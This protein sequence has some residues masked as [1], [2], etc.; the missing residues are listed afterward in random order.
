MQFSTVATSF[1]FFDLKTG[2]KI[3][4]WLGI[5]F[6]VLA[7][8]FF[9]SCSSLFGMVFASKFLPLS[10]FLIEWRIIQFRNMHRTLENAISN[11][12]IVDFSLSF[13]GVSVLV[14]AYLING[15]IKVSANQLN[16]SLLG[17][18]IVI[19]FFQIS[20]CTEKTGPNSAGSRIAYHWF[21]HSSVFY[22]GSASRFVDVLSPLVC[23]P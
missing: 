18:V 23:R 4:G 10:K 12:W 3:I 5:F 13:A 21:H 19:N 22:F 2:G 20:I 17:Y 1:W 8:V 6:E 15:I 7:F 16:D 9:L 14:N 11:N